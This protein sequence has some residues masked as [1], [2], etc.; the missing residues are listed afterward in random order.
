MAKPLYTGE[1]VAF[2]PADRLALATLV[3][4]AARPRCCMAE[5]G[6]WL[7]NGSTQVFLSELTR[8]SGS[9]LCVDSWQG[10]FGVQRHADLLDRYDVLGTFLMNTAGQDVQTLIADSQSAA[11]IVGDAT[12][13]LVFIDAD[14]R[15]EAVLRDI[16]AWMPKVRVGGIL[17]GHDCEARPTPEIRTA[18]RAAPDADAVSMTGWRFAAAHAGCIVA[19]DEAFRGAAQLFTERD[20]ETRGSTIWFVIV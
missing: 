8:C 7:G 9:L 4:R 11:E 19:V 5:I 20:D 1:F 3:Q 2:S 6:S 17:C 15:Y 13:D 10:N 16:A 14:H 12:F 18:L